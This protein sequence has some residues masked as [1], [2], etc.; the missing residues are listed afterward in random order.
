MMVT[1]PTRYILNAS[2]S[3]VDPKRCLENAKQ[4]LC[5]ND[6]PDFADQRSESGLSGPL[7]PARAAQQA[8]VL[9]IRGVY[10]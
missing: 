4:N 7:L 9:S 2:P 3:Q 1:L 5:P 10:V 8:P 6:R